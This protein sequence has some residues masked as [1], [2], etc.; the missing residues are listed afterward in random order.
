MEKYEVAIKICDKKYVDPLIVAL[1][2]QG[3]DVYYNDEEQAV[4]FTATDQEVTQ[5]KVHC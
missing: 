3:Y 2:R 5:I 4:C 1:V